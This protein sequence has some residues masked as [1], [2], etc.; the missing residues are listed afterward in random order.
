MIRHF[1]NNLTII[2]IYIHSSTLE[3]HYIVFSVR[4]S[5]PVGDENYEAIIFVFT[6]S[7]SSRQSQLYSL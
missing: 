3:D 7:I 4:N 1:F 2:Y 6:L 5:T